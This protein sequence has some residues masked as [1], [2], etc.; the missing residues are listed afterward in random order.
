MYK[1]QSSVLHVESITQIHSH[2]LKFKTLNLAHTNTV[3]MYIYKQGTIY[4]QFVLL[5]THI[6][7]SHYSPHLSLSYTV[8]SGVLMTDRYINA[9]LVQ[10][11]INFIVC[12][13]PQST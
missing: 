3:R 2:S 10:I 8:V 13:P 7:F 4:R 5:I 9:F 11:T 12:R 6:N 1:W